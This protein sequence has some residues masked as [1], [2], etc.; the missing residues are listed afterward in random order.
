MALQ[1][2]RAMDRNPKTAFKNTCN[3]FHLFHFQAFI[4][5]PF[6]AF[7]FFIAELEIN[8]AFF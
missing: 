7:F 2:H 4:A 8:V 3:F 1:S 6:K 5:Q